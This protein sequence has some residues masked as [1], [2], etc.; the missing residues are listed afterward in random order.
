ME[1]TKNRHLL[2]NFQLGLMKYFL[3]CS[4]SLL[5]IQDVSSATDMECEIRSSCFPSSGCLHNKPMIVDPGSNITLNCSI[6]TGGLVQGITWEK[7]KNITGSSDLVLQ[8]SN[9]K[10]NGKF[11]C[12]CTAI[13]FTRAL[14]IDWK[15]GTPNDI[16]QDKPNELKCVISGWPLPRAV[17]WYKDDK[18]IT[19]GTEGM[20]HS[21]EKTAETVYSILHLP[22]GRE[23]Q[24][25]FYNC[26][27]MNSIP[28]WSSS[29]SVKIQMEY[30]CPS[31]SSPTISSSEILASTF[32]NVSLTCLIDFDENCPQNQSWYFNDQQAPL[33]SGNKY[34]VELKETNRKCKREYILSIFNVSE[35][36]E[37]KYSCNFICEYETTTNATIDLKVS[38]QPPTVS[39]SEIPKNRSTSTQSN[40]VVIQFSSN[41]GR[42]EW[43][44]PVIILSAASVAVLFMFVVRFVAMKK[45]TSSYSR[46]KDGL[47]EA[48][49]I[50]RLFIS[51]SSKDKDWVTDNL[52]SILE[53]HSIDYS[54]HSRDFELGKP[55][56]QNMADNVYCSRQVLIVLSENYLASNFCREELHMAVQ[57]DVDAGDSSLI[58]VMIN[59]L[60]KKQLPAALRNKNMLDFDKHKKKQDWEQKILREILEGK[61]L[62][63]DESV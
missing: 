57:R 29:I 58:L 14:K 12:Q 42:R 26:S 5:I 3:L 35:N 40:T 44:L 16:I 43:Q 1:N 47:D 8:Q 20:Y 22:P 32:S 28:G 56:V 45:W 19:N 49:V 36:D 30:S 31:S 23:E 61:T 4:L 62:K 60:K 54:I 53:K 21:L 52:I 59:K 34:E 41:P 13:N 37:G 24:E 51:F 48:D 18:L 7:A 17:S 39:F 27:A 9:S 55:I 11:P 46:T 25:G 15:T 38:A 33:E 10:N 50:N 63:T 2:K 6:V